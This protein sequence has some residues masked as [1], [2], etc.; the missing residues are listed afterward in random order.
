MESV[1]TR[2]DYSSMNPQQRLDFCRG[3]CHNSC[4]K[5]AENSNE[6]TQQ[7][8]TKNAL[9]IPTMQVETMRGQV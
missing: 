9:P 7:D 4:D 3:Q 8:V 5:S 2:I 6:N 1:R